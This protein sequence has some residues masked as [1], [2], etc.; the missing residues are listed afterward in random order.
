MSD[1][2]RQ[3]HTSFAA[4]KKRLDTFINLV[5]ALNCGAI[6]ECPGCDDLAPVVPFEKPGSYAGYECVMCGASFVKRTK[7]THRL[8]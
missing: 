1:E 2:P 3:V 5:L 4:N 6:A 8:A 7:Y